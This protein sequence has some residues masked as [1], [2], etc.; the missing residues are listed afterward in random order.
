[1]LCTKDEKFNF[2]TLAFFSLQCPLAGRRP[3]ARAWSDFR[4]ADGSQDLRGANATGTGL[5]FFRCGLS[6]AACTQA[7][8]VRHA[9]NVSN[10]SLRR[11]A[12][13]PAAEVLDVRV[14]NR[15]SAPTRLKLLCQ[16]L[17]HFLRVL[18]E[19]DVGPERIYFPYT[20]IECCLSML[21]D[22]F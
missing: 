3:V 12:R 22:R 18:K 16:S 7:S 8:D 5:S 14:E 10:Y 6:R 19:R 1:M 15:A 4:A 21:R 2:K 13:V 20:N 9:T 17:D 11:Y